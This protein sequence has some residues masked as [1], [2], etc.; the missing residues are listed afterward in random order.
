VKLLSKD[1]PEL[2]SESIEKFHEFQNYLVKHF[3]ISQDFQSDY[4]EDNSFK[5]SNSAEVLAKTLF[6]NI[7]H[8]IVIFVIMIIYMFFMLLLRKRIKKFLLMSFSNDKH[9]TILIV[10]AKVKIL[11][12]KY[13]KGLAIA[14]V[15][16]AILNTIGLYAL[17]IKHA[18]FWA[19]LAAILNL[20][21][22]VGSIIAMIFPVTMAL[23]Y[24]DSLWY[25][26]GVVLVIQV[27]HFIYAK[28][29][30]PKIIGSHIQ[31]NPL[32]T[33]AVII[34]G[35]ALWGL[36]G[37]ILFLPLLGIIKIICDSVPALQ[38]IGYLIGEEAKTKT[39]FR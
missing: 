6:L 31:I 25:T 7:T 20:I 36:A 28:F 5:F 14:T 32:A 11:V 8:S 9:D 3:N 16:V 15:I 18:L 19:I 12:L 35:G 27:S 21:P 26:V 39:S 4:L 37:M 24:K 22:Y 30:T 13:I 10:I 38:P 17:D 34:I 1:I 33:I 2:K 29:L 23:I